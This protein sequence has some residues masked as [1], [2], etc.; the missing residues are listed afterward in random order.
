MNK[1]RLSILTICLSVLTLSLYAQGRGGSSQ[2]FK[3]KYGLKT[4]INFAN[5]SNGA[6][7]I[8]FSPGVKSDFLFGAVANIHF[9]YRNEGSPVGT[10]VFGLQP[11]LL[12][13]RQGFAFDG[14]GYSFSY[15]TLPVMLKF[16]ATK[17]VNFEIGPY[18]SSLIGVSPETTVINGTQIALSDLKGGMDA[19][20]GIG[21]EFEM[22]SGLTIGARYL[23]GLSDVS[24]NLA[25]KNNVFA[26]TI[27]WLF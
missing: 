17:D 22:K 26:L 3:V 2:S 23:F 20:L 6:G 25:W 5:I 1:K 16:Y 15:L 8:D 4:G 27:G 19:G 13:S 10:G 21:A 11:E 7:N 14:S 12:Y 9:G 18:F 24:S